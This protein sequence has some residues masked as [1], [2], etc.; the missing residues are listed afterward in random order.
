M[1]ENQTGFEFSLHSLSLLCYLS[2]HPT[3]NG[4]SHNFKF[5]YNNTGLIFPL[6]EDRT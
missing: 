3:N 5:V 2:Y 6:Y 4:L 1:P